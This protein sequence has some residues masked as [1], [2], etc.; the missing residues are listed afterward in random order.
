MLEVLVISI[1][2]ACIC[3]FF[4]ILGDKLGVILKLAMWVK[5]EILKRL[6]DCNFCMSFWLTAL[7]TITLV[8]IT[9]NNLLFLALII[10]PIL[11]RK[12]I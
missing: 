1:V 9:H 7:I 10:S 8:I 2:I 5:P 4:I 11:A 12:L 6:L 3:A